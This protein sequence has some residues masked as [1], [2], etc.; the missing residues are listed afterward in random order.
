MP[1]ASAT[2]T[3]RTRSRCSSCSSTP[4]PPSPRGDGR[5]CSPM[6]PVSASPCSSSPNPDLATGRIVL[7]ADAT[8]TA[9]EPDGSVPVTRGTR[10]YR[11]RADEAVEL[12][13]SVNEANRQPEDD[14]DGDG[15]DTLDPVIDIQAP[16]AA[17]RSPEDRSR[18][19]VAAAG[20]N[21]RHD[22][23]STRGQPPR[24]LP[25]RLP[26]RSGHDRTA[27]PSEAAPG[28]VPAAPRRSHHRRDRRRAVAR[29]P[30][31]PS[32]QAVLAPPRRPTELLPRPRRHEPR[33]PPEGRRA[34]PTQ[35]R[36]DQLRPVGLRSRPRRGRR[37]R[38]TTTGPSR[39]A[40]RRRRLRRRPLGRHRPSLDRAGPPGPAPPCRRRPPPAGRVGR[41][42]RRVRRS[43]RGL[44]AGDRPRP[45]RR[46][47]VPTP[48]DPLRPRLGATTPCEPRGASCSGPWPRSTSTSTMPPLGSTTTSRR[49]LP[50]RHDRSDSPREPCSRP[51]GRRQPAPDRHGRGA[52]RMC[53]CNPRLAVRPQPRPGRVPGLRDGRRDCCSD[54]PQCTEDPRTTGPPGVPTRRCPARSHCR[55]PEPLVAACT[56]RASP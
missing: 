22:R 5:H 44:G 49:E 18:N 30:A 35:P 20:P 45:L 52:R 11:L 32:A 4:F 25:H 42:S 36:R 43:D 46:G 40:A 34:L 56:A 8:V 33:S 9:V 1:P 39:P 54:R 24:P 2:R 13:G 50:R 31:R 16:P 53:R 27:R 7:D 23:A 47:A 37:S 41:A 19:L 38:A 6:P 26:R 14:P 55:E 28:L 51:S 48:H 10:L 29:H 21:A 17:D 12:L 3:P 15:T